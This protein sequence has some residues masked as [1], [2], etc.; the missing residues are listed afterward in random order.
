MN[1][2][3][4]FAPAYCAALRLVPGDAAWF[5]D[6]LA[7]LA[8]CGLPGDDLDPHRLCGF[9]HALAGRAVVGNAGVIRVPEPAGMVT[10][11][12]LRSVAVAPEWRGCGLGAR[13]LADRE[14]WAGEQ[15]LRQLF[16][17]ALDDQAAAFF[18]HHGYQPVAW[19]EVPLPL[20][21]H[22][23]FS[24]LCGTRCAVMAKPLP[25]APAAA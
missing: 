20:Q 1:A 23:E 17:I 14:R 5:S 7:L 18:A 11:G 10:L 19:A 16:L 4:A 2:R 3:D 24:F 9:V 12:L 15:G 6:T 21:Q 22:P 25:A 13:L 8:D